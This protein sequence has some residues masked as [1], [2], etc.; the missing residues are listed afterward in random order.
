MK[1]GVTIIV[2][3][4]NGGD[5]FLQMLEMIG[6]QAYEG[7]IQLVVV[8]SGS[9]DSTVETAEK[10][11]ARIRK[12]QKKDFHH[13]RTR[14]N[15]LSLAD[16]EQ[17]VFMVQDAV[18]VST[19]WLRELTT[20]L[21]ASG[22]VAVYTDQIPHGNATPYARLETESTSRARGGRPS[23]QHLDSLE[24][25]QEMPYHEAYRRI[26]LDN[27]CALY[28]KQLLSHFPFPEVAFAEDMAWAL[29]ML[30]DGHRIL[31][32]PA[33][34]VRHSHNR[35]ASYGFRRQV[36]NSVWCA[37]IMKRVERDL[38][39]LSA[40]ELLALSDQVD[41]RVA[42]LRED[43][44]AVENEMDRSKKGSSREKIHDIIRG[45]SFVNRMRC[46]KY[47]R[48]TLKKTHEN[49]RFE[50][51]ARTVQDQISHSLVA[52]EKR[53]PPTDQAEWAVALDQIAANVVGRIFGET[54]ASHM[55]RGKVPP[56][57]HR[58]MHPF[59]QGV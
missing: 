57:I 58:F 48:L 13:A 6:L 5:L 40:G 37:R 45:S 35:S 16:F 20:A 39:F 9:S 33:V 14:N 22:A 28:R 21:D 31:Y 56:Q 26:N 4:Y 11:G 30:I 55:V 46:M 17:V 49:T 25:F 53:Y 52:I 10:W 1:Q 7:P 43:V 34:K 19:R 27:V 50:M 32:Q 3:T 2:P 36:I 24:S 59:M 15:A 29:Q 51:T 8:D 42:R 38:S 18:P 44:D 54:Y 41:K 12:I 23:L 47:H